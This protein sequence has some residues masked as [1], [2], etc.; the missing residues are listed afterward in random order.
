MDAGPSDRLCGGKQKF[1]SYEEFLN[2]YELRKGWV[3]GVPEVNR[4]V[5]GVLCP[6]PSEEVVCREQKLRLQDISG[7]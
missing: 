3:L 7:T 4:P 6:S 2:R 1:T 5:T